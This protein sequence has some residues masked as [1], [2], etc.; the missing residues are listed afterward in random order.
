MKVQYGE[1]TLEDR[2][3]FEESGL[4]AYVLDGRVKITAT[5]DERHT[6]CLFIDKEVYDRLGESY[7]EN[8]LTMRFSDAL[9]RWCLNLSENDYYNNLERHPERIV[10]LRFCYIEGGTGRDVYKSEE[11]YYFLRE[12]HYPRET[13]A[14][15]LVCGKRRTPEDGTEPRANII[16]ECNGQ[17]ERVRYDD[18]NGV[19]A[20]GD[21]FNKEFSA[22][23]QASGMDERE[24]ERS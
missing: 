16:F 9:D 1:P 2:Q 5:D 15:W 22:A 11:G 23:A 18:W 19:A 7:I 6:A 14:R 17:R 13:F 4:P 10:H 8:H 3:E 12:N 21:T 24:G 20:Y